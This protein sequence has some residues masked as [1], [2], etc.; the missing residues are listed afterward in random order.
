MSEDERRHAGMPSC[1]QKISLQI[2][3]LKKLLRRVSLCAFQRG[4][5]TVEAA[6]VLPFFLCSVAVLLFLFTV[7]ATRAKA[8]REQMEK[9]E[10]LAVTV[11]RTVSEDPYIRLYD[12]VLI[13]LPFGSLFQERRW[14]VQQSVV[15]AWIGYTGESFLGKNTEEMVYMTPEGEVCHRSRDCTY[16]CLSIRVLSS[17]QLDAARNLSGER[18]DP[19]E[20]CVGKKGTGMVVYITNYGSSYHSSRNAHVR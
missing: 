7:T 18:Y 20:Y 4:S 3:H 12:P 13:S 8:Y 6:A 9:A 16:L 2:P 5:L 10:A 15:R 11:G 14:S 17:D 19:C 1:H